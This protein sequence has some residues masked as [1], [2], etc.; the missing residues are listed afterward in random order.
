MTT[1][2]VLGITLVLVIVVE[3]LLLSLWVP[4]YCRRG[5]RV[6]RKRV[7]M[8]GPAVSIASLE[9][10]C[11]GGLLSP[12]LAFRRLSERE[13]AFQETA[14]PIALWSPIPVIRGLILA[15]FENGRADVV[16][17]LL[18]Y[19]LVALALLFIGISSEGAWSALLVTAGAT[20]AVILMGATQWARYN[21]V[22]KALGT[23]PA[24]EA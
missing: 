6:A 21:A 13:I 24:T 2:A 9:T 7:L 17:V 11:A 16:A 10:H 20:F 8:S 15:D 14:L 4:A 3:V 12:G 1:G 5:I 19:P 23:Q 22:V 18:W